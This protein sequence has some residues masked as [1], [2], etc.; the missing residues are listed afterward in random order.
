MPNSPEKSTKERILDSA[1]RLFS[2][3]G[4]AACGMRDIVRD[5][6]VSIAMVNYHFGSKKALLQ[7]IIRRFSAD[8]F[9]LADHHFEGAEALEIK[10]RRFIRDM[11]KLFRKNPDSLRIMVT[12]LPMD[13]PEVIDFKADRVGKLVQLARDKLFSSFPDEVRERIHLEILGPAL[14]GMLTFHFIVHP[15]FERAFGIRCDDDFY[16]GYADELA[17]LFLYGILSKTNSHHATQ[18]NPKD[19]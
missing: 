19:D 1:V 8:T 6:G 2:Q 12:E 15:V 16:D 5:A 7:E 17:D 18:E 11:I 3:K 14:I 4:Y 9:Q 10:L 13:V